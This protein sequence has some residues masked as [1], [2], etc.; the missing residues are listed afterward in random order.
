MHESQPLTEKATLKIY[1]YPFLFAFYPVLF[2]YLRNIREVLFVRIIPA[3][4]VSLAIA[5]IAWLL[6]RMITREHSKRSLLL[7]FF[8]LLFYF[9]GLY[10]I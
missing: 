2:L 6:T 3:L 9:Y 10:D 8:L 5:I 7:F 4:G 1:F